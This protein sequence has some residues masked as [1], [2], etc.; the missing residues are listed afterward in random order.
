LDRRAVLTEITRA[1][2]R[3]TGAPSVVF[4][5]ADAVKCV[6][7]VGA[8]SNEDVAQDFP[9]RVLPFGRGAVGWIATQQQVLEVPDVLADDRF[10]ARDWWVRH[11]LRSFYGAPVVLDG[12]LVAVLA[13]AGREPFQ[14]GPDDQELLNN[15]LTVILGR[16]ELLM[17]QTAP[18]VREKLEIALASAHSIRKIVE[19]MMRITRLETFDLPGYLELTLDIERSSDDPPGGSES[20]P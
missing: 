18:D 4:Y 5:V 8:F 7:E 2:A 15:P 10:L 3:L 14:F 17:P 6:L 11:G 1:A 20:P 19:R 16:I 9:I 13:L 12:A